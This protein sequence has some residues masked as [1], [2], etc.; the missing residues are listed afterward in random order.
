MPDFEHVLS[1]Q[2]QNIVAN[3]GEHC[4][5]K[6][7][8]DLLPIFSFLGFSF[9]RQHGMDSDCSFQKRGWTMDLPALLCTFMRASIDDTL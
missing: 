1:N 5:M 9:H 4:A 6:K 8:V 3:I 7:F 2:I